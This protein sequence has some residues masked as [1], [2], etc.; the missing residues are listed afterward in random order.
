[1]FIRENMNMNIQNRGITQTIV[2]DPY[3]Q[4]N[5]I[6]E[7]AWNADYDGNEAHIRVAMNDNGRKTKVKANL[8][9]QDLAKL[10]QIPSIS[11]PLEERLQL[12]YPVDPMQQYQ[13]NQQLLLETEKLVDTPIRLQLV[14]EDHDMGFQLKRIQGKRIQSKRIQSKR[15]QTKRRHKKSSNKSKKRKTQTRKIQKQK[16]TKQIYKTPSP[17]TL[18]NL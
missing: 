14:D 3:T 15:I 9:N 10:F 18:S 11:T 1:M 4:G 6:N 16:K 5:H 17:F 2:Q 8:N 7:I 13:A 12:D